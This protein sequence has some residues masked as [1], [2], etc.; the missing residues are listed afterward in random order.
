M[1]LTFGDPFFWLSAALGACNSL[2]AGGEVSE[3]HFLIAAEGRT[4]SPAGYPL[5]S[6]PTT[7]APGASFSIPCPSHRPVLEHHDRSSPPS[8]GD[9]SFDLEAWPGLPLRA[10][11]PR[12][13]HARPVRPI[14]QQVD[15]ATPWKQ[16][17]LLIVHASLPRTD[18]SVG[19]TAVRHLRSGISPSTS[20]WGP[21]GRSEQPR[22]V[23]FMPAL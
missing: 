8:P 18:C 19:S 14:R 15:T 13:I 16:P 6:L 21:A 7:S 9:F 4:S 17:G 12:S 11:T 3:L 23:Q 20:R 1:V 2:C 22:Q 5:F 10:A